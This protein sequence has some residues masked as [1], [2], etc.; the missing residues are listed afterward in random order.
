MSLQIPLP[1]LDTPDVVA[2]ITT[3][4]TGVP[5]S[6][7]IRKFDI[8]SLNETIGEAIKA[9]PEG[10]HVGAFARVDLKG[11]HFVIAGKVPGKIPGELDWTV[12]VDKPWDGDFDAGVGLRWS[13]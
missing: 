1:K 7:S 4:E 11:A 5:G 9:I 3:V 13:I 10:K 6:P 12:F 2:G 8:A